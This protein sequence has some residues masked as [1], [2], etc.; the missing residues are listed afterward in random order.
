VVV[1][2]V[3][4]EGEASKGEDH[5]SAP[6]RIVGGCQVQHDGHE[7]PYVVNPSDL[8]MECNDGVG[9][10]SGGMGEHRDL[11]GE[12]TTGRGGV[13]R[14]CWPTTPG[15]WSHV[16]QAPTWSPASGSFATS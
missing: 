1:E 6:A 11:P 16:L 4:N 13:S 2:D 15:T 12:G 9:V 10:E 3:V 5:L 14:P 8:G 7:G